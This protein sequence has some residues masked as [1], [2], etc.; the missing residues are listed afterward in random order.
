MARAALLRTLL[1]LLLPL[2]GAWLG[3]LGPLR[4]P[5]RRAAEAVMLSPE[6]AASN[7][8]LISALFQSVEDA[9]EAIAKDPSVASHMQLDYEEDGSP[10]LLRFVYVEESDCIGCTYCADIA[11][12]T[13]FMEEHAGRARAYS[14]GGDDPEVLMEAIDW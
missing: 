11:R 2:G 12:N 13:F 8:R 10:T 5:G 9:E 6:D 14:Q 1:L 3:L 4:R 7:E